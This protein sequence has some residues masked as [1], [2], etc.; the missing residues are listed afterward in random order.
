MTRAVFA[1]P[2]ARFAWIIGPI[3]AMV[4]FGGG[5]KEKKKFKYEV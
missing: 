3:I 5:A 2:N 1:T 4:L